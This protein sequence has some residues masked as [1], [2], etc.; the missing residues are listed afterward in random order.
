MINLNSLCGKNE[1]KKTNAKEIKHIALILLSKYN[2]NGTSTTEKP[3]PLGI[4]E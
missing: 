2:P 1:Y 3:I 4:A